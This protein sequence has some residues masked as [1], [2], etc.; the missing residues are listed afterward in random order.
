MAGRDAHLLVVAGGVASKFQHLGCKSTGKCVRMWKEI[1]GDCRRLSRCRK[2]RKPCK[3][4]DT[5]H[6]AKVRPQLK[7]RGDANTRST[8]QENRRKQREKP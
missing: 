3:D 8:T 6:V 1:C 7:R 2:C 5:H 4:S